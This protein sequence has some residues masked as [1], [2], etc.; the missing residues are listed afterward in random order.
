MN[1]LQVIPSLEAGGAERAVIDVS[2]ALGE[3]GHKAYVVS[4]GG[5]MLAELEKTGAEHVLVPVNSKNPLKILE[6]AGFLARMIAENKIDIVHARSRAPA[7]SA[8]LACRKTGA[9]FI[10]TFHAAYKSS[11]PFK[12]FYNGI[13]A[14]SDAMIAVSQFI[15]SYIQKTF[16]VDDSK[17]TVIPR[18][19]DFSVF[20]PAKVD[21]QRAEKF[22]SQFGITPTTKLIVFP[23]RLSPIKGQEL[24][25]KA[26]AKLN[27]T[28]FLCLF[29]GP[30][31]GREV[32]RQQLVNLITT[33]GMAD[34]I[35]L[36]SQADLM[37]AYA[38]ADLVLSV[39]QVAE[40]FGRVPVEAQAFGSPVIATAL[41]ATSETVREGETGW[42]V[43]L[44]DENALVE[45][46]RFALQ[47]PAEARAALKHKAMAHV[48]SLF[49]VKKM[50]AE[51]LEVYAKVLSQKAGR[52]A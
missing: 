49:D 17:I 25:I 6:N 33:L 44:G 46:I 23:G 12:T 10:T 26:L 13:M 35:K 29:I 28:P 3:A 36:V 50:C 42:L 21:A 41:G 14:R 18:G 22:A 31:Q 20:D 40:G 19:I 39:S 34:K 52:G 5:R 9:A 2:R 45:K 32:Y 37:A 24:A 27:E 16:N 51:T 30:D 48:R 47:L 7:W 8:Y 15:K 43:P 38:R 1:V 11:N 4:S